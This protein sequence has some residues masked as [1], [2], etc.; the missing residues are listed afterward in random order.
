MK[1]LLF[2]KI[3]K[4]KKFKSQNSGCV[5]ALDSRALRFTESVRMTKDPAHE[6]YDIIHRTCLSRAVILITGQENTQITML[7]AVCREQL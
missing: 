1:L 5:S 3:K 2:L 6:F 7:F 4:K